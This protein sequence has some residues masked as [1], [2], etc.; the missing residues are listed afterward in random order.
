VTFGGGWTGGRL[1]WFDRA[2]KPL[3]TIDSPTLLHNPTLSDDERHV[4][5]DTSGES[6]PD[7]QGVWRIDLERGTQHR[8]L[9]GGIGLWSPD[10]PAGRFRDRRR[11]H[12]RPLPHVG[13]RP[14]RTA[15]VAAH[16]G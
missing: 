14:G 16:A 6:N 1:S 8:L 9:R 3:S 15:G 2:G 4:L 12:Q 7:L 13:L 11:R 5:A 10:R